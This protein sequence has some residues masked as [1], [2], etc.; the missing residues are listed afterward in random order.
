[1]KGREG[2]PNGKDEN[3]NNNHPSNGPN[4]TNNN[5]KKWTRKENPPPKRPLNPE[6]MNP[7]SG[8]ITSTV[9]L[10]DRHPNFELVP[11]FTTTSG[12][13]Q[14]SGFDLPSVPNIPDR[15]SVV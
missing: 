10:G 11:Y 4:G 1:M 3:N 2:P 14:V 12:A 13:M 8:I 5:N 7:T 15:K 9:E 6:P